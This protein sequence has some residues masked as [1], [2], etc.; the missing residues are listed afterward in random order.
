MKKYLL[1][2]GAF[3]GIVLCGIA[4]FFLITDDTSKTQK[5]T[6]E[7]KQEKVTS[8][9]KK[10]KKE[11][12]QQ[13]TSKKKVVKKATEDV[14]KTQKTK[15]ATGI[16]AWNEPSEPTYPTIKNPSQLAVKV[17]LADQRVYIQEAGQT[18]Y[19][20]VCSTGIEKLGNGTPKGHFVI[21]PERGPANYFAKY[22]DWAYNWI[23]FKNHGEYLFHSVLFWD[24]DHVEEEEAAKLGQEASHGCIRMSLPDSKWFYDNI[25][26]GTPVDIY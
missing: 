2:I 26:T 13:A 4:V 9:K 16:P 24:K 3:I 20:I 25:P 7:P 17:S 19:T 18:I 1:P 23:S 21:E 5:K 15:K 8:K 10:V 12:H 6:Q 14:T 11:S 22:N